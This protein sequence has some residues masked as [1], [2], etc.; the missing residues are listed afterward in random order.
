MVL[1]GV[2]GIYE[3][4]CAEV[5]NVDMVSKEEKLGRFLSVPDDNGRRNG[6]LIEREYAR[7]GEYL[8]GNMMIPFFPLCFNPIMRNLKN[9]NY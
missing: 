1:D 6:L 2:L 5:M 3:R 8:E 7:E 9:G 4:G